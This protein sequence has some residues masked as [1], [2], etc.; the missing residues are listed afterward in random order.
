MMYI[1]HDHPTDNSPLFVEIIFSTH[2]T[3][4]CALHEVYLQLESLTMTH[5]DTNIVV[6]AINIERQNKILLYLGNFIFFHQ[7][8][9]FL[10][11]LSLVEDFFFTKSNLVN[12]FLKEWKVDLLVF[13]SF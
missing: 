9:F 7:T 8:F 10:S 13:F 6:T 4:V 5:Q 3:V 2:F 1:V 12:K 11:K